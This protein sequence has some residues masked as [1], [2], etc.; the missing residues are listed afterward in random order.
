LSKRS[1]LSLSV[2]FEQLKR[3]RSYKTLKEALI[4]EYRLAK[5]MVREPD[6]V[7]GVRAVIIDKDQAPKWKAS[8][9][10]EIDGTFVQSLFAPLPEGDLKLNDYWPIPGAP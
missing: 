1:P 3:G 7:E 2:T 8:S 10:A 4:V 5:R 6:L 9:L